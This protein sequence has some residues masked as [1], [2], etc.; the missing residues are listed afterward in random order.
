MDIGDQKTHFALAALRQS[1]LAGLL[2]LTLLEPVSSGSTD[3]GNLQFSVFDTKNIA[4][5]VTPPLKNIFG[6]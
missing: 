3:S 4:S 1:D 6:G 5:S 2:W